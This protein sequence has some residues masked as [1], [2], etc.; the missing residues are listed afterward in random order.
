MLRFI[1]LL[2]SVI[3]FSCIVVVSFFFLWKP[4]GVICLGVI[5]LRLERISL[6]SIDHVPYGRTYG[7][8]EGR[9]RRPPFHPRR[10]AVR[11]GGYARKKTLEIV[12]EQ[13][14]DL[15]STVGC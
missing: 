7:R 1:L 5:D 11:P 10:Q 2:Q 12:D 6:C 14:L 13:F 4:C 8:E 9:R 3:S 15:F